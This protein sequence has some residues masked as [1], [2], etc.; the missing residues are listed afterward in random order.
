[1]LQP[2]FNSFFYLVMLSLGHAKETSSLP[3]RDLNT[4]CVSFSRLVFFLDLNWQ[5]IINFDVVPIEGV[6]IMAVQLRLYS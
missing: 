3:M 6:K 5:L 4:K 2:S 1:M